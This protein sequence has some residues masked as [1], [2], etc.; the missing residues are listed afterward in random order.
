MQPRDNKRARLL[1]GH[2][3]DTLDNDLLVRCASYL[4]AGGLAQLGRTSARFGIPQDDQRR[5]LA[6]EAARQRFR[7]SATDE[8]KSRLPKYGDESDVGLCPSPGAVEAASA[9]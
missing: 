3:L 6:N 1:P 5:S 4:D 9:L 8:E 2:T 7:H